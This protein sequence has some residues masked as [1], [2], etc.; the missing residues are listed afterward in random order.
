MIVE[1]NDI[2]ITLEKAYIPLLIGDDRDIT[3]LVKKN[4]YVLKGTKIGKTKEKNPKYLYSSISGTVKGI[5]KKKLYSEKNINCLIIENDLKEKRIM[6]HHQNIK[7]NT[8]E[9]LNQIKNYG[10]IEYQNNSSLYDNYQLPIQTMIVNTIVYDRSILYNEELLLSNISK[11]LEILDSLMEQKQ[12]KECIIV[13]PR[14]HY[15]KKRLNQFLGTYPKIKLFEILRIPKIDQERNLIKK[16][17]HCHYHFEPIE[18]KIV[19]HSVPTIFSI[20]HTWKYSFPMI[21]K[22]ILLKINRKKIF[23]DVKIGTEMILLFPSNYKDYNIYFIYHYERK[24]VHFHKDMI[25]TYDLDGIE[26]IGK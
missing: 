12:M 3:L 4:D 15:I 24:K 7:N 25:F 20:Y 5:T 18:Q 17:K 6:E 21:M 11:F 19:I 1:K 14:N 16:I 26:L 13:I 9:L 10:M 2:A 8:K 23:L 22:K